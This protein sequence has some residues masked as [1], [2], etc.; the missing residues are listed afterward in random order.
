MRYEEIFKNKKILISGNTGFKGSWLTIWLNL[1]GAELYGISKDIPTQPSLFKEAKLDNLIEN[2]IVDVRDLKK[3]SSIINNIKPDFIFHLAAQP[4]VSFSYSKPALTWETNVMG[5]VNI[6]ESLRQ[7]NKNCVGIII[8]SDKC[9]ENQEWEWG[10]RESDRLGGSD[11]YSA[12][13]GSAELVFKS[14]Y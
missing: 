4:L 1:L 12:S 6:L 11:P 10:Y 3:V 2:N 5:T 13:K 14:Y 8:T 9:Y 7:L